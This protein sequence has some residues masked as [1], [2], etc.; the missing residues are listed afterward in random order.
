MAKKA[1]TPVVHYKTNKKGELELDKNGCKIELDKYRATTFEEMVAFLKEN[2]TDKE[3]ADFKTACYTKKVYEE[4]IGKRGGKS[5]KATSETVTT[6]T[7]NVLYAKEWFFTTF[8]PEYLPKK[9]VKEA[10]KS[11]EDMLNELF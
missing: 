6:D 7:I 1:F 4:V 5:K 10:K 3:K 8:A 2:G 11:M 9:A